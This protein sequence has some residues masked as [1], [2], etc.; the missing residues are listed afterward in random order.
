MLIPN[1]KFLVL[2][3]IALAVIA[4]LPSADTGATPREARTV[5]TPAKP[6]CARADGAPH[7]MV[8]TNELTVLV[9]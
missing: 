4:A 2:P 1:L 5:V 6:D 3:L 7:C 8:A 9:R